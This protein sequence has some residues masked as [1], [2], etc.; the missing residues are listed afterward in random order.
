MLLKDEQGNIITKQTI[1]NGP[2]ADEVYEA[3]YENR[4][5]CPQCKVEWRNN[6]TCKCNDRCPVC[7]KEITPLESKEI[8]NKPL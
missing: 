1:P 8:E 6:W 3:W 4:Y 7:N 5:K 2:N